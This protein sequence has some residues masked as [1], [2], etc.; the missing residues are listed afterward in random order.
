MRAMGLVLAS[1]SPRRRALL[2]EAGL[3]FTIEP[4]DADE[5]RLA[6]EPPADYVMR[7]ALVKARAAF[8]RHAADL[9]LG[10]DTTV[11]LGNDIL[12]KPV[13]DADARQMLERLSGRAHVVLTGVA[14]VWNG[15]ERVAVERTVVS[16]K[17][18]SDEDIAHYVATGEPRDK[19]GAYAIQGLAGR[20]VDRIDGSYSNVVGLPVAVVLPLLAERGITP[21]RSVG[22]E[23]DPASG[24]G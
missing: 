2:E 18:L 20:F 3:A 9:V 21:T 24:T 7:L 5:Q 17:P 19:A 22:G 6:G 12:G 1:A 23:S 11:A 8:A 13:D 16:F 10:A 14:L 15:G 4:I